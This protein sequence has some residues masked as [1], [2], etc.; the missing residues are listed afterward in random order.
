MEGDIVNRVRR[1]PKPS[2]ASTALQPLFEAVSNALH[3]IEDRFHADAIVKGR[4]YIDISD[5][6]DHAKI[7][8]VVSDNGIGID[9]NRFKAFCTT[10]TDFKGSAGK[11]I[12][13][14]LWLDAFDSVRIASVYLHGAEFRKRS[15]NFRRSCRNGQRGRDGNDCYLCWATRTLSRE[16]PRA[17]RRCGS[18][19]WFALPC[20][21]HLEKITEYHPYDQ[22]RCRYLVSRIDYVAAPRG[23]G[24][25][26]HYDRDVRRTRSSQLRL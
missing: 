6:G 9:D 1:L 7:K 11:G 3:A 18:P 4:I 13:R 22:Q 12:G 16:F 2:S 17:A 10:D 8:I 19:F 21:F 25:I 15:L 26:G 14:L 5:L 24:V 23:S 20:G